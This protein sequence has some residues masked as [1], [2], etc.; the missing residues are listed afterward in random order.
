MQGIQ[1]NFL[2]HAQNVLR[3]VRRVI[4]GKNNT[5]TW[6]FAAMLAKG[7]ILMEDIPGV[8]KTTMALAFA[9]SLGLKTGRVQFTPDILP[10]DVVGFSIL[11]QNDGKMVYRPGA[12]FC[13]IFLADELNRAT[14]RTQS[15]LLEAMEEG[16]VTVD[17]ISY[18]LE[19][20]FIV[21]A[22]QNPTGAA[23]TQPLPDSQTDRFMLRLSLGYPS[24]EDEI[25]MVTSR[26]GADPLKDLSPIM[27]AS[28]L[29]AMQELVS[30]TYVSREVT[31][32]AVKLVQATRTNTVVA[33]GASPRATLA[34]ISLSKA[35]ARLN[36][37][38]FVVPADVQSSFVQA[39]A[40][41][42]ELHANVQQTAEQVLQTIAHG[43]VPPKP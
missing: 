36:G 26:Q 30:E 21:I 23:G 28:D 12:V 32:Y 2:T 35:L 20:P 33:R 5:L 37:R 38:D 15:A 42:I 31:A 24:L 18:P 22:T 11:D 25:S 34:L 19:Q 4:V 1:I 16:Q 10:S 8:G 13:N 40:H 39:V 41:R 9:K 17:G 27:K 7:H 6:V 29:I 43:I 14:S 3:Q